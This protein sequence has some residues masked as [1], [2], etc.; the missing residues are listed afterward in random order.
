MSDQEDFETESLV[1]LTCPTDQGLCHARIVFVPDKNSHHLDQGEI[2]DSDTNRSVEDCIQIKNMTKLNNARCAKHIEDSQMEEFKKD[3]VPSKRVM[4]MMKEIQENDFKGKSKGSFNIT[5]KKSG[6]KDIYN[7]EEK[8]DSSEKET[9]EEKIVPLEKKEQNIPDPN[10]GL[11]KDNSL[12]KRWSKDWCRRQNDQQWRSSDFSTTSPPPAVQDNRFASLMGNTVDLKEEEET[13]VK[14]LMVF[15]VEDEHTFDSVQSNI[16]IVSLDLGNSK[17]E[18]DPD[19]DNDETEKSDE[20]KPETLSVDESEYKTFESREFEKSLCIDSLNEDSDLPSLKFGTD[21]N[22]TK[23]SQSADFDTL[24][25]EIWK[26]YMD[27]NGKMSLDSSYSDI[28]SLEASVLNAEKEVAQLKDS[29]DKNG[30]KSLV[31]TDFD[32]M[33]KCSETNEEK[34][35]FS[36]EKMELQAEEEFEEDIEDGND[37]VECEL[38]IDLEVFSTESLRLKSKCT[39]ELKDITNQLL[40]M[41]N[42]T[43]QECTEEP[44]KTA[45]VSSLKGDNPFNCLDRQQFLEGKQWTELTSLDIG[46]GTLATLQ[47]NIGR[48]LAMQTKA[49]KKLKKKV[50][51]LEFLYL[52]MHKTANWNCPLRK[53]TIQDFPPRIASNRKF[54]PRNTAF[55]S[56]PF[57]KG[58]RMSV[59]FVKKLFP[60]KQWSG[61]PPIGCLTSV[62][63]FKCKGDNLKKQPT[64][65][66]S[67]CQGNGFQDCCGSQKSSG[68]GNG[69]KEGE[70]KESRHNLDNE[71][72]IDEQEPLPE[73]NNNESSKTDT[74][75]NSS[76]P[77]SNFKYRKKDTSEEEKKMETY[78]KL[79]ELKE[80]IP[81]DIMKEISECLV[82]CLNSRKMGGSDV[83]ADCSICAFLFSLISHFGNCPCDFKCCDMC[84]RAFCLVS[85]HLQL[86][87]ECGS[88]GSEQACPLPICKKIQSKFKQHPEKISQRGKELWPKLK[89]YLARFSRRPEDGSQDIL[90]DEG[91]DYFSLSSIQLG[92]LNSVGSSS[93]GGIPSTRPSRS[94]RSSVVFQPNLQSISETATASQFTGSR[95]EPFA[96]RTE[97]GEVINQR[98]TRPARL[99][100]SDDNRYPYPSQSR[101][102][103]H[104]HKTEEHETIPKSV[105]PKERKVSFSTAKLEIPAATKSLPSPEEPL[106]SIAEVEKYTSLNPEKV[107]GAERTSSLPLNFYPPEMASEQLTSVQMRP[108]GY[109]G[110]GEVVYAFKENLRYVARY[111]KQIKEVYQRDKSYEKKH[112]REEGVVLT[113]NKEKFSIFR[114]RYQKNFQWIRLTHL[115]TGMSGKCHLA[116]DYNTDFKFCIK[117]INILKFDERELDI[118]S[119]LSHPNIVQLYGAIRHGHNIYIFEE[120]ID[121][122]CLTE[123][124]NL[125]K[126]TGHRLSH[127]T[128]LNYLQQILQVLVYLEERS[129]IHEDIKADNILLRKNTTNLVVS[130]FGVARRMEHV[131]REASPVGT[132]T[133]FSPEKAKG[134]G[135]GARSDVWAAICVLIHMLSGW[136]PWV[137]R[138]GYV[139]TLNFIIAEREPPLKDLPANVSRDVYNLVEFALKKDPNARPS[140]SKVL[141]HEAFKL[142]TGGPAPETFV[143]VLE[144]SPLSTDIKISDDIDKALVEEVKVQYQTSPSTSSLSQST[145]SRSKGASTLTTGSTVSHS[146]AISHSDSSQ[147]GNDGTKD[148]GSTAAHKPRSNLPPFGSNGIGEEILT[149]VGIVTPR[150]PPNLLPNPS[151]ITLSS[152][153][154]S[155]KDL[156]VMPPPSPAKYYAINPEEF[157]RKYV[158]DI[159]VGVENFEGKYKNFLEPFQPD[160][161]SDSNSEGE[162]IENT[163][164]YFD[165]SHANIPDFEALLG[166]MVSEDERQGPASIPDVVHEMFDKAL[167]QNMKDSPVETRHWAAATTDYR[168]TG[169]SRR[170]SNHSIAEEDEREEVQGDPSVQSRH[171]D[172]E[173]KLPD[174]GSLLDDSTSNNANL[175]TV[176]DSLE[177]TATLTGQKYSSSENSLQEGSVSSGEPRIHDFSPHSSTEDIHSSEEDEGSNRT[178]PIPTD[179]LQ[180]RTHRKVPLH[181]DLPKWEILMASMTLN[182]EENSSIPMDDLFA[183][184]DEETSEFHSQV[185]GQCHNLQLDNKETFFNNVSTKGQGQARDDVTPTG[186]AKQFPVQLNDLSAQMRPYPLIITDKNTGAISKIRKPRPQPV[187]IA[188]A[189]VPIE[190]DERSLSPIKSQSPCSAPLSSPNMKHNKK[191]LHL[192]LNTNK[193]K[194]DRQ[195]SEPQQRST[196][197]RS[198]N[199]REVKPYF[200]PQKQMTSPPSWKT[201]STP[202]KS[203]GT[204]SVKSD[205]RM[206]QQQKENESK[207]AEL[208]EELSLHSENSRSQID[209]LDNMSD[210]EDISLA[211]DDEE[212]F[213]MSLMRIQQEYVMPEAS[214]CGALVHVVTSQGEL[215]NIRLEGEHIKKTWEE[216]IDAELSVKLTVESIHN[217]ILVDMNGAPLDLTESPIL[218]EQTIHVKEPNEDSPWSCRHTLIEKISFYY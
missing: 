76:A 123:T 135:H 158:N 36:R 57:R 209:E 188:A 185:K 82:A 121:G 179:T 146:S 163:M 3:G 2:T 53:V 97:S 72:D 181:H 195:T 90:L 197:Y 12:D 217:F 25:S 63:S 213:Q 214:N 132:P 47:S 7:L 164:D 15:A 101:S 95:S 118:W 61:L 13:P 109:P 193:R 199:P 92:S 28:L 218:G 111:W 149:S 67:G 6:L 71:K 81:P 105:R 206:E 141:Q 117:K 19:K 152:Y 26:A 184:G 1:F 169:E 167:R 84:Q 176:L 37:Y 88:S 137:R 136:P 133:S 130:D 18:G 60:K 191:N 198:P 34:D 174:L 86:C 24:S 120:F 48:G 180:E 91:E 10:D 93:I 33:F 80:D 145:S 35:Y 168:A 104:A 211:N 45:E 113:E 114:T 127:W 39:R 52:E 27:I 110:I 147:T 4:E 116:Q 208:L 38:N 100:I 178:G 96:R 144:S 207:I 23:D 43:V 66:D 134:Q 212:D 129:T 201:G 161:D 79:A 200:T 153:H 107:Y 56:L 112:L 115:G 68:E 51:Q 215:F 50:K 30:K 17:S 192:N 85:K 204:S 173:D 170:A 142:L 139:G 126:E 216:V 183:S 55:Q 165:R 98:Q 156:G 166:N 131:L 46:L 64:D 44:K 32:T 94:S 138:Y 157:F 194:T 172:A 202:P 40:M 143:S 128:A 21:I 99:A 8:S 70:N 159:D 190:S 22:C 74:P 41:T 205:S 210:P 75:T 182:G 5:D 106:P 14:E 196:H 155:T 16:S 49:N 119:D 59:L 140:A 122:G 177:D 203:S 124:I 29:L 125:Q 187:V 69:N 171:T 160:P 78:K 102:A 9:S 186:E 148:I 42:R 151:H 89:K 77:S 103:P 175:P 31:S 65:S 108:V 87:L 20:V 54:S 11:K 73:D 150:H 62:Q 58:R 162:D 83:V 154:G 189:R